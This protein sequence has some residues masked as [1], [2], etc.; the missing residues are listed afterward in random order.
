[1][2]KIFC[3]KFIKQFYLVSWPL[4]QLTFVTSSPNPVELAS[5]RLLQP[6]LDET[7]PHQSL[8]AVLI[9]IDDFD[10]AASFVANP[11]EVNSE[12]IAAW[13]QFSNENLSNGKRV[14]YSRYSTLIYWINILAIFFKWILIKNAITAYL[15]RDQKSCIE[16]SQT[17]TRVEKLI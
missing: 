8:Y 11:T 2:N 1:M 13:P 10:D 7:D 3:S 9:C 17:T 6:K 4:G 15:M 5:K 12:A 14:L 16:S